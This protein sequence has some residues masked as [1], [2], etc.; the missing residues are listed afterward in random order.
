MN[1]ELPLTLIALI[2]AG[3]APNIFV[4]GGLGVAPMSV[5]AKYVLLPAVVIEGVIIVYARAAGYSRLFNRL[6]TGLWVG[7][8]ATT[9]LDVVRQPGTFFGYL[10]HDEARMAGEMILAPHGGHES[11]EPRAGEEK[12]PG[13]EPMAPHGTPPAEH[14]QPKHGG[15]G[16]GAVGP[17]DFVGYAYHYWNGAS[18]AAVYALLFGKTAWW[19]PLLYSLLFVETGMM[20]FMRAAMGPLTWGIF[21]VSLFAHVAFG[22]VVGV[23]LQHFVRDRGTI[24]SLLPS[25]AARRANP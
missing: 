19:G 3:V 2:C 9:G 17:A 11:G 14:S 7:A 25:G 23:L 24:L 22:L 18:F 15:P 5:L 1:L 4:A 13:S 16:H 20:G 8:I 6:V 10:A 21:L 12:H